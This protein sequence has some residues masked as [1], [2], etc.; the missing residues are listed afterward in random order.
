[1]QYQVNLWRWAR[2]TKAVIVRNIEASS[3][4][5]ALALAMRQEQMR[6]VY[7]ALI[8]PVASPRGTTQGWVWRYRCR[9]WPD[10][11]VS[12]TER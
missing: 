12:V 1:M 5:E 7:E 3:V 6:S 9:L 8:L 10:G 2:T 11:R 4:N